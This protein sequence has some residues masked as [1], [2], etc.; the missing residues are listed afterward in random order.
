[1]NRLEMYKALQRDYLSNVTIL[2]KENIYE[3][4]VYDEVEKFPSID[5]EKV[6]FNYPFMDRKNII[7]KFQVSNISDVTS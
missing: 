1:M 6:Q 3:M 2:F 4:V 7:S 5:D